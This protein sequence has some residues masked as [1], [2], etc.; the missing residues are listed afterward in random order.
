[1]RV[2]VYRGKKQEPYRGRIGGPPVVHATEK[3][4]LFI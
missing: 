1:M 2:V 4:K 3:E